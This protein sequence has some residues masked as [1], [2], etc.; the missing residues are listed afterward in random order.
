MKNQRELPRSLRYPK[1]EGAS[2]GGTKY[3]ILW[4]LKGLLRQDLMEGNS[5]ENIW[6]HG[7][8]FKVPSNFEILSF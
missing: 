1:I 2:L 4:L 3:H 8:A 6:L 5:V 7:A